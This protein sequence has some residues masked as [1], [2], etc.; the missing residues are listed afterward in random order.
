M[1]YSRIGDRLHRCHVGRLL[2]TIA[3]AHLGQPETYRIAVAI[4]RRKVLVE[5]GRRRARFSG[6]HSGRRQGGGVVIGRTVSHYQ[7]V[8]RLG[9][10]GMGLVYKARDTRLDRDVALKF[11]PMEWS[12]EPLLRERFSREARA[13]SALDHPNICTVYDIGE[14]DE[15]QLFIAMAYC[16][17]P[18]LKQRIHEGPMPVEQA[19]DFA[20]QIAS[21]LESAHEAGIVHRDIKPANILLTDREQVKVVDFGLAK[22]AGEAAVTREGSVIGTPAYMSPEQATGEEVDGRSDLWALGAV[23]YEMITGR[24]AFAADHERAILHSILS[25]DPTPIDTVRPD[26]PS[27]LARI[28]RRLLKRDPTKRYQ[29]AGELL[30]DLR[31]FSGDP[32]PAEIVT[33]SM[34]SMPRIRRRQFLTHRLLPAVA[35]VLA[36][37]AAA[38]LYPTISRPITRHVLV[39]PFACHGESDQE[40][41]VC[42][43]LLETVTARLAGVRQFS[44]SLSVVPTSE[45]RGQHIATAGEARRVFG[46]DLVIDGGVQ[47]D[48]GNLRIPLQLVDAERLRQIRSQLLTVEQTSNFVLQDRVVAA[49]LEMLELELDPKA[50]SSLAVGGTTNVEAA[51]LYLEARGTIGETATQDQLARAMDLYRMAIDLDPSYAEALVQLADACHRQYELGVDPIWLDHGLSYARR[52][53]DLGPDLPSAQLVAGQCELSRHAYPEAVD[54]LQRAIELDPLNLKAY[55]SLWVAFE[56][57]GRPEL[58]QETIDRALRTRPDDWVTHYDIGRFFY[59]ERHDPERAIPYF[60]KVVELLPESSIG[61]SA[62]G[63]C[64]FYTGET[65]EAR[66]N[67]ERA[68]AIGSRYEAFANLATLDFYE[69]RFAEAAGLYERALEMDASDYQNWSFL[70]EAS[71]FRRPPDM[72]RAQAAYHQAAALLQPRLDADPDDKGLLIE[73]ASFKALLGDPAGARALVARATAAEV[74]DP[75]LMYALAAVFEDLG[76]REEALRWIDRCLAAG[77]PFQVIRDYPGFAGLIKDPRFRPPEDPPQELKPTEDQQIKIEGSTT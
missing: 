46:V 38:V 18:T 29:T 65:V 35:A 58:A 20:I 49:V 72:E 25:S 1:K 53:I 37:A 71:R 5:F 74:D 3:A 63:S 36:I 11:L 23:L 7:I 22:L 15:G 57:L 62:L 45:V 27:E 67:L 47:W 28:V 59:Y 6:P 44:A 60:E 19:V 61:Y 24:R 39:L 34:P 76:D 16:T 64:Q 52:A 21:A 54:R 41:L 32:T 31:R 33:Q 10:G 13:A 50:E 56:E 68:A 26:V 9:G 70:G 51:Q 30:G 8:E 69:G 4:V 66:T 73:M 12:H 75:N 40:Q 43:G 2:C 14:T 55:T 77:F 48:G 42:E 17:G